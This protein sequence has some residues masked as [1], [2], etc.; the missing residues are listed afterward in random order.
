MQELN[1]HHNE[2]WVWKTKEDKVQI[3]LAIEKVVNTKK[4]E[5]RKRESRT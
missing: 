4:K 5:K 1:T 2:G 3:G